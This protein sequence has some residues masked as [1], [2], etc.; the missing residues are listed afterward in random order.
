MDTINTFLTDMFGPLGPLIAVGGLGL[1][2]VL[3]TLPM[4]LKKQERPARQ[5]QEGDPDR[6]ADARR[7]RIAALRARNGTTSWRNTPTSSNR[8]T[9][10][11]TP[12][13]QLKLLQAG[14]PGKNA[15]RTFHFCQFALGIGS[16][17]ARRDLRDLES[18][19][20][21]IRRRNRRS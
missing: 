5:A 15:V 8:R 11:N 21:A 14:Y 6:T 18:S 17:A 16:A 9:R 1:L 7:P 20:P 2:L 10:K 13:S 19:P 4:L 3:L 12:R